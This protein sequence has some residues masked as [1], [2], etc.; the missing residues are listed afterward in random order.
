MNIVLDSFFERL[1]IFCGEYQVLD[2]GI[3]SIHLQTRDFFFLACIDVI[4]IFSIANILC[5]NA[6]A[7]RQC[8]NHGQLR[9]CW[10]VMR[11]LYAVFSGRSASTVGAFCFI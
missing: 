3:L 9:V 1:Y 8:R 11:F 6:M 7:E 10:R 2:S 5:Q 4:K